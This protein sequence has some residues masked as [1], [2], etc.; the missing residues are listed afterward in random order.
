M[1]RRPASRVV[2]CLD[3]PHGRGVQTPRPSVPDRPVTPLLSANPETNGAVLMS[4]DTTPDLPAPP[5]GARDAGRRLWEAVV[6]DYELSEHEL[7]LLRQ[8]VHVVDACADL[9]AMV[10]RDGPLRDGRA[11]PAL[12]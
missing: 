2:T 11:H 8:A 1:R 3:A 7:A 12:V 4:R 6:R 9:Q 10:D 5:D